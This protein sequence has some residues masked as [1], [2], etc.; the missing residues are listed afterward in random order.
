[1]D[2]ALQRKIA[3]YIFVGLSFLAAAIAVFAL[4]LILASLLGKGLGGM[5]LQIFTMDTPAPDSE[6]GLRNAIFGSVLMCGIAMIFALVIG[7]LAGTWLAEIGGDTPYGHVVRFLNDV[8]L[9]APSIL[10]GL[11][12]YQLLVFP[13]SPL[14]LGHFSGLA[15]AA[16]LAIIATPVVTR[17]TE[18]ILNLQPNALREAGQALGASQFTTI[19]Q[20]I[21]KAA[22]A[23]L[24][25]GGLLGFAR[26]SGETAPLLFTALS[27]QFMPDHWWQV[28]TDPTASLPVTINNFA[29]SAVESWNKLAWAA[30]LLVTMAVLVI[31]IAGRLLARE[32]QS[33]H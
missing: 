26:I 6:G 21:W 1:M 30:A 17:T 2:R 32:K 18:D 23:G 22:G 11:F 13:S 27:N 25:T 16:A 15:G 5:N 3:N 9:S 33:G 4:G 31:N 19:R 29:L 12:V 8:L 14:S 10:V 28:L 7:I 24:L 20:I